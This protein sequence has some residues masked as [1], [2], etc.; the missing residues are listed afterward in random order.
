MDNLLKTIRESEKDFKNKF[1]ILKKG[2][3]IEMK[4]CADKECKHYNNI[5]CYQ[6]FD[7]FYGDTTP[8]KLKEYFDQSRI[9][10]LEVIIEQAKKVPTGLLDSTIYMKK[11]ID[12]L[13]D[14]I[15]K[16]K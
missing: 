5:E 14:T 11:F 13:E 1:P 4:L 16:L 7:S 12:E 6:E 10:E 8:E 9:K 2:T 15:K 3:F